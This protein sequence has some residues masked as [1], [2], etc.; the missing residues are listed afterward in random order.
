MRDQVQQELRA[1]SVGCAV[2]YPKPLHLQTCFSHLGYQAGQ[3]PES[4]AASKSVLA[5]PIYPELPAAHL[6]RVVQT[7]TEACRSLMAT[8]AQRLRR[9]A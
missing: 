5:L 1:K 3:F 6:E 8:P 4:E 7:L 2:Y 9:A